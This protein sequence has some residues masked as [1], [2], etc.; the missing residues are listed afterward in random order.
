[1]PDALLRVAD[2][3]LAHGMAGRGR[4]RAGR[5]VLM[6]QPPRISGTAPGAPLTL[7]DEPL[8]DTAE[9]LALALDETTLPIQGPPGTGKTYTGARMIL[10]LL[11][12]GRRVGITAQSHKAISNLLVEICRASLGG[13]VAVRAVQ[14][15]DTGDEVRGFTSVS[16]AADNKMVD[17]AIADGSANLIAGTS[18][19]FARPEM[20]DTLDTLVVDEAGQLAL[21][22]VVAIAGSARSLVLLGDPNQLPQVSQGV[23]P[24]GVGISALE[25][26]SGGADTIDPSL[27]LFLDVTWRMH[28]DVNDYIS[29]TFYDGRLRARPAT[30][31]QG[32]SGGERALSGAGLRYLPR[33]HAADSSWSRVEAETVA[34]V[35]AAL[36]GRTWT[37]AEG[38]SRPLVV[39][40]IIVVAPYNAHVAAIHAAVEARTG[41]RARVGTVDKFQGQEGAVAIYS[42]ASSSQDDAPRGMDFLF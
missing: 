2:H 38:E 27:G 21:A 13:P 3:V 6:R 24:D 22:N 39:D 42:M 18:W 25:H 40:D 12:D 34:D 11:A 17:R 28:P 33:D 16:L 20:E 35:I 32:V 7:P 30:A 1:M 4:Y 26:L 14:R 37:N 31:R 23:H 15:C 29:E 5:D 19:L 8:V 9:R 41:T 10:A 36:L